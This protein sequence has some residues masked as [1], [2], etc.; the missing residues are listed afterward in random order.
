MASQELRGTLTPLCQKVVERWSSTSG[1]ETETEWKS[2]SGPQIRQFCSLYAA[3]GCDYEYVSQ[4]GVHTLV[5][6][7]PNSNGQSEVTIDT[8][9]IGVNKN[10]VSSLRNPRN[11]TNIPAGY[12]ELIGRAIKDGSTIEAART[13]LEADTGDTYAAGIDDN[14]YAVRLYQRMMKGDDSFNFYSYV[15]RHTTNVS[16]RYSVN[17]S[18]ENVNC[19]YSTAGL[20][21]ETQSGVWVY[22]LPG[23]LRYKILNIPVPH[24]IPSNYFWGWLKSSSPESTTANN[25]VNI[26]TEY[27]LGLIST[28]EYAGA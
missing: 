27:E 16:N 3:A 4:F 8:W 22:P 14:A 1:L 19:Y 9:E 10:I 5:A 18:D 20:L 7:R 6:R 17:V 13:A 23:R 15:L 12:L 26:V 24:D 25:R 2:F 21:S 28:D 11:I